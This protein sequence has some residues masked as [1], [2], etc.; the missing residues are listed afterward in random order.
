[1]I[2]FTDHDKKVLSVIGRNPYG[3]ELIEIL[4]R[5]RDASSSLDGIDR[6]GDVPAQVQGRLIFKDFA[7]ELIERLGYSKRVP[8]PL[9]PQEFE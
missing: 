2:P 4:R 6:N 5:A 3:K 8:K 9:N 1:M 7:D